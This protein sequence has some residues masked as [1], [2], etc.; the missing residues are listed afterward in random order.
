MF[1]AATLVSSAG[2]GPVHIRNMSNDGALI[3]AAALPPVESHVT[4]RRGSLEVAGRIVWQAERR[5]G[6]AFSGAVRV[7]DWMSRNPPVHQSKVD[8]IV[9][10]IR[11]GKDDAPVRGAPASVP[12][13][14]T[15]ESEL[16]ALKDELR[17]V[18]DGL[19]GSIQIVADHPEIQLLDV[20]RQRIERL[21][22]RLEERG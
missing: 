9:R 17:R 21:L 19:C 22:A 16:R 2:S 8:E 11:S 15:F 1:V 12:S 14:S 3:E 18:E 5:A 13:D 6:L 20:A 4:L 10:G 7:A